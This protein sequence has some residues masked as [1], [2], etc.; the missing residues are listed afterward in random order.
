MPNPIIDPREYAYGPSVAVPRRGA[1]D[2]TA[3]GKVKSDYWHRGL[4]SEVVS[5][6]H[7]QFPGIRFFPSDGVGIGVAMSECEYTEGVAVPAQSVFQQLPPQ[8]KHVK[9]GVLVI[10]VCI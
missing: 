10:T 5:R 8:M 4:P 3:S 9:S 7:S 1:V 6:N 2:L